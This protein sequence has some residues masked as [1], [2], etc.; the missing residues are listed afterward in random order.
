[1]FRPFIVADFNEVSAEAQRTVGVDPSLCLQLATTDTYDRTPLP[2][3]LGGLSEGKFMIP[4]AGEWLTHDV[5]YHVDEIR[6]LPPDNSAIVMAAAG[7]GVEILDSGDKD[8]AEKLASRIDEYLASDLRHLWSNGMFA[9]MCSL[10]RVTEGK[11]S[12]ERVR[13]ANLRH[14][15]AQRIRAAIPMVGVPGFEPGTNRL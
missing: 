9:M 4:K 14:S 2:I 3:Y 5:Q 6:Q 11:N 12:Q 7:V 13:L 10:G 15:H 1:M 8:G